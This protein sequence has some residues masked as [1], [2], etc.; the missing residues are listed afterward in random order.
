MKPLYRS[1]LIGLLLATTGTLSAQTYGLEVEVVSEDIGVLTGPLGVIDLTGYTCY[2]AYITMENEDD[3]FSSVSGDVNNPTYIT[4]T[5]D[6]YH[7]ALGAAVPNGINSLLFP[8]Y[9]ELAYDSWVTI[10]LEGYPNAGIG[11]AGVST[12]QSAGNPWTTNF[13]PG[14]GLPGDNIAIDDII[15]GAWYALNG[16][17]N[18]IAGPDLKVLMGQFTTTGELSI[19]CYTQIFIN[20]DSQDEVPGEGGAARP[21]FYYP[22]DNTPGCTDASACNY[23]YFADYD[24]GTCEFPIDLFGFDVYDCDGNCINDT[25]GDGICDE[26][27]PEGCTDPAACNY[28]PYVINDDG[29]C[30]FSCIGCTDS[31]ACNYDLNATVDSGDCSYPPFYFVDCDGNCLNDAD[32]DGLC[33]EDEGCGD[34]VACNYDPSAFTASADYCLIVDTVAVHTSGN[35]A[36]MTTYRYYVKCANPADFVSSV[37]GD[38]TN[39]TV[40][41]TTTE[42]YQDELGGV[43]PNGI[44]P[45]LFGAFPDLFYDSWVTIGLSSAPDAAIGEANVSTVQS[46]DNPWSTNFEPGFGAPGGDIVINDEVGGAWYALNG[47]NNGIAASHPDQLVLIAQLTTDGAVEGNFYVQI[48]ENGDGNAELTF[49]FNIGDACLAPDDDCDYPSDVYGVDYVDCD[50]N[51]LNDA[52]GDGVCDE[53][54]VPGCTDEMA[55]NYDA[56]ATDDNGLCEYPAASVFDIIAD[57]EVH[58]VLEDLVVAADLAGTLTND[59]PWTVFAPTDAAVGALSGAAVDALLA[60]VDLLA[61]VLTYH[62]QADST[63]SDMLSNGLVLDMVNG[64]QATITFSG[65]SIFIEDA[66]I[67]IADLLAENGVV[68]VIDA[69]I[70]P[71]IEGCTEILS[72]NYDPLAD[73]DDGSCEFE[74]CAGCMNASACNFDPEA[75]INDPASCVLPVD[76]WGSE[77]VDC[78]G[79]CLPFVGGGTGGAS[80]GQYGVRVELVS[81]DIGMLVG[82]L[83]TTDLSGYQCYRAYIT[84]ENEDDFLSAISGD[85]I[86]P[87]YVTTT[88]N[89]YHSVLGAAVPNGINSLLFQVYPDLEFDSWVTIGLEGTPNSANGEANIST[90]QSAG[91]PWTTNFDPGGGLPGGSIA[92]DDIIGGAWYALTGD[93][94]GYAGE[95]LEVLLG[96]FTTTG[97]LSMQLYTQ[98]FINGDGQNEVPGEGGQ[99]RPTFT[100]SS[101]DTTD[102]VAGCTDE[103]ACNHLPCASVDDGSCTYPEDL[104]GAAHFDCE[105]NCLNDTDGDGICDEDEP[106]S[107]P[108]ACDYDGSAPETAAYCLVMDTVAVHDAGALAGMTTY[109]LSLQCE[110]ATDFVSAVAGYNENPSRLMTSTEFY[111]NELGGPTPNGIY[112]V[113]YP[114]FP[115]LEYDSWVTIGLE[116]VPDVGAGEAEVNTIQNNAFPWIS[117]FDPGSGA[118]GSSIIMN[119]E[120]GGSWF[121]LIGDSNAYASGAEQQVL[122]AQLTTDG[123]LSGELFIQVFVEGDGNSIEYLTLDVGSACYLEDEDCAYPEDVYGVDYVDCDG[124]CLH[125]TDGDGICDE[126]EIPGCMDPEACNFEADATDDD[127]GCSYLQVNVE[128]QAVS[129]AGEE[130]GGLAIDFI[131][132]V[133]P[134][135][136]QISGFPTVLVEDDLNFDD[137]PPGLYTVQVVDEAGCAT[138][139]IPFEVSEPEPLTLEYDFG[140]SCVSLQGSG[141]DLFPDGGTPPYVFTFEGDTTLEFPSEGDLEVMAVPGEFLLFLT[142]AAGCQA[143][144]DLLLFE[145]CFGCTDPE[146]CNF[147]PEA[148]EEDG[149]CTYPLSEYVDCEGVCFNDADGDGVCDEEEIPGC[150][151][152][153]ACNYDPAATD[154]NGSCFLASVFFDCE[155]NCT[156]DLNGNGVCDFYEN[157]NDGSAFCGDGTVWDPELETCVGADGCPS[158][159]DENGYVGINDL[160]DLLADFETFCE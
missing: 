45:P 97:E 119:D 13:D 105:G 53:D 61:A 28:S 38:S 55:L 107:D 110:N 98:I 136:L 153:Y 130:D 101:L 133:P 92:I 143:G 2:R 131:D 10:G 94:N 58:T 40:V 14:G 160:L 11:E 147:D 124:E 126:E 104:Y 72:C 79:N 96:Q 117:E 100:W 78:E 35:L 148:I 81:D 106:C 7:A 102:G 140:F 46:S 23:N 150:T 83:G 84:M 73:S 52:D 111:Q 49:S 123:E 15:G 47:D 26:F 16:D 151:W 63:T 71:S 113:L 74:S 33:D 115:D 139:F 128:S 64:Q 48:F 43:T 95:D 149:S 156:L 65:G 18:G 75:T 134:Y 138:E 86:N 37:S 99:E 36:G 19:Q 144:F 1:V 108:T 154:E 89:F 80:P 20:G 142:D 51:C 121:S 127:G 5:T 69:V 88:T 44:Q 21:T 82:A 9:P 8:V 159:V 91:N 12:V 70:V 129:C 41:S 85:D 77:L 157:L 137:V 32:G 24:D 118:P 25:D 17:A 42:F 103:S 132:G 158:D 145:A 146:A 109:R 155:G 50:G 29:S 114:S 125:D 3:F 31:M 135:A 66:E 68:H 62:V 87:T 116:Q 54:E 152:L 27:Y 120:V 59:G 76:L 30:D 4:T 57:S 60:D 141:V 39:P 56:T 6:F 67:I 90:V 34:P 22:S 112:S 122:L 93:A